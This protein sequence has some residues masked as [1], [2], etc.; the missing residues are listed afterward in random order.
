MLL[1]SKLFICFWIFS[2]L[3]WSL[4]V[5]YGRFTIKKFVNRGFLIGPLCPIYGCGCVLLFLLLRRYQDD[6]IML[7]LAGM[8]I[9]SILEYFASYI[10]EKIFK[11]RWWDY[12]QKKFNIN[13]RICLEMA[14]PFGLLGMVVVYLLFPCAMNLLS[15]LPDIAIYIVASIIF[16][17]FI[18][19]LCISFNIVMKF[20]KVALSVP[21]DMTEE[22]TKF[23]NETLR[24]NKFAKRILDAFPDFK[25]NPAAI[26]KKLKKI[27]SKINK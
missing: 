24:K 22:I 26:M 21:K 8:T 10:M 23:V 11:T 15:K 12:S 13:G 2:F 18:I 7:F 5:L 14:V 20:T 27:Q 19:D 25:I 3:G 6:P 16:L 4:E 9:C 17:L 1:I